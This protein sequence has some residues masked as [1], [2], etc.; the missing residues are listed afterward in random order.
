MKVD[1]SDLGN[2][3]AQTLGEKGCNPAQLRSERSRNSKRRNFL[4]T[5][6]E[7]N[8]VQDQEQWNF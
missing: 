1:V 2:K 5:I 7:K 4:S 6:P 8:L 3:A